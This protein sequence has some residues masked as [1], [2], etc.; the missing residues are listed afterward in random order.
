[1]NPSERWQEVKEILY[2]ALEMQAAE[3]SS[4]L[5]Q[6][7]GEDV[8]LRREVE[9]LIAAHSRADER[10]ESPAVEMMAA[11]VSNEQADEMAGKS[12]GHYEI[13]EK[14]GAGGMGEVYLARDASLH[15]NVALKLLPSYFTQYPDR[16][17]RFQ[18]EARAASA[19]NHPNIV[20]VYEIGTVDSLNY[21]ATEFVDGETV[22]DRINR[23]PLRIAE[24]LDIAAQ[25]ASALTTAHE[26][27]IIHRDIKPENIMLRR[28]GIVK[29]VDFGLAKLTPHPIAD[30]EAPTAVKTAEGMII[31]TPQYMSPEQARCVAVD[32]RTDIWS[33]G[34]VLYEMLAGRAPFT[35]ATPGDVIVSILERESP[36][37]T[38]YAEDLPAELDW[39]VKKLLRKEREERYQTSKELLSDLQS[40]KRRFEFEAEA[41]RSS[42]PALTAEAV[43]VQASNERA[44]AET[45]RL[46]VS[47][48]T[49]SAEYVVSQIKL[50]KRG[51]ALVV[52]AMAIAVTAMAATYIYYFRGGAAAI[53]SM[54]V[55]PL[56]NDGGD[57]DAEYL[58]DGISESLTNSLSQLP[59]MRMIAR[60]S[61]ERY[62]GHEAD[63]QTVAREL[64]VEA[65][66]TGR[67]VRR[68][69]QL[70][71]S[72]EL[73]DARD[74]RHIWGE[75]YN[76]KPSDILAV[77]QE[78]AR[79]IA[80]RL[81]A[82]LT[83][84]ER[85][86]VTRNYTENVEA[87]QLYLR[88]RYH[89]N[90][91]T[92][93][94][95]RQAIEYFQE[96]I[97]HDPN[98]ALAYSGLADCYSNLIGYA[99]APSSEMVPQARSAALRALEI[100]ASLA[101]A[102]ASLGLIYYQS[103]QWGESEREL[104]RAIELNPNYASAHHWYSNWLEVMGRS[105]EALG[106]IR[107]AQELDPLS[108]IIN[109]NLARNYLMRGELDAAINQCRKVVELSPNLP[110]A[111]T[112]LALVYQKQGRN[113][114]AIAEMQKAVEL[115][116]RAALQ[117]G[118]LGYGYAVAGRRSEALAILRDLEGRYV[119]REAKGG[120]IALIYAGLGDKDQAFQWLERDF[121]ERSGVLAGNIL[122]FPY[123]DTLRSDPRYADLLRRMGLPR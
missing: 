52:A 20:T 81:R 113:E 29:V 54:V 33:L 111:H 67:I 43:A 56:A 80:E 86:R 116:G 88:G 35:G 66:L 32:A 89:W 46:P 65:I 7:C 90:K 51:T 6:K 68:G 24:V 38:R 63:P 3:R 71:V 94:G 74:N 99:G 83:G 122:F 69:E 5:D 19:L 58:S 102:H 120:W 108:P 13:I 121:Q 4:F 12:L 84:E 82:R 98:Y 97:D 1:M 109:T 85:R 37:L 39:L 15:R 115:S 59:N 104:K 16:V 25:V 53:N 11:V 105:D 2:P 8:D 55:L 91:R 47:H 64:G 72:V 48:P 100:D 21:I 44:P 79:D 101:E 92:A 18:Q 110:Q 49:S 93:E 118:A 41:D 78:I 27:G 31:G 10:F 112:C 61:A 22:R 36:P 42:A 77:Q 70:A 9:A 45:I 123:L 73:L 106:E 103:W 119:R 34:C 76:R 14:I 114:E 23:G 30:A 75:Q 17:G 60:T 26:A 50:H 107:R 96:A 95:L 117:F 87:Y 28:D 62:K 57:P 40:L